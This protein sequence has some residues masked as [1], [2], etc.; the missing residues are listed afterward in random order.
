M[1]IVRITLMANYIGWMD[2]RLRSTDCRNITSLVY[3]KTGLYL[4]TTMTNQ[5]G[6]VK[7]KVNTHTHTFLAYCHCMGRAYSHSTKSLTSATARG[8]GGATTAEATRP[9]DGPFDCR[10]SAELL[11]FSPKWYEE[12]G[13]SHSQDIKALIDA[14]VTLKI[15]KSYQRMNISTWDVAELVNGGVDAATAW[16]RQKGVEPD[17]VREY[18]KLMAA[19]EQDFHIEK[20]QSARISPEEAARYVEAGASLMHIPSIK[21]CGIAIEEVAAYADAGVPS[22][23]ISGFKSDG[24]TPEE[25]KAYKDAGVPW[26]SRHLRSD[27]SQ[28]RSAGL[29]PNDVSNYTPAIRELLISLV[30][31]AYFGRGREDVALA[32]EHAVAGSWTPEAGEY[33]LV[34]IVKNRLSPEDVSYWKD[35]AGF[36]EGFLGTNIRAYMDANLSPQTATEYN[37]RGIKGPDAVTLVSAGVSADTAAPY[38]E[39][40]QRGKESSKLAYP[41]ELYNFLADGKSVVTLIDAGVDADTALAYARLGEGVNRGTLMGSVSG[42]NAGDVRVLSRA[43]ITPDDFSAWKDAKFN[44]SRKSAKK[45]KSAG[46]NPRTLRPEGAAGIQSEIYRS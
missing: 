30:R 28:L 20:L 38:L 10:A 34:D 15:L 4:K 45:L 29:S 11:G 22:R 37:S 16:A 41:D 25:V 23:D 6:T 3:Y 19:G 1:G 21:E 7:R 14:R 5:A 8:T 12:F 43:G 39:A 17:E 13:E 42:L 44:G 9:T 35:N 40:M 24:V 33:Q 36:D 2:L 27:V 26:D 18:I 31:S 46:I 32:N